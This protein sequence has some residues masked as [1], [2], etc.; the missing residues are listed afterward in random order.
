MRNNQTRRDEIFEF[1][2]IYAGEKDGPTPSIHEIAG[3]FKLSYSTIYHHVMKLII[4]DRLRQEDG[5]L[6]V[7]NSEWY[8]P[9][10]SSFR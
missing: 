6:I 3:H 4:E 9:P 1:I 5:K 7:I 10:V 2:I 8:A